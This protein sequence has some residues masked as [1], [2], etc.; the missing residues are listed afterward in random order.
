MTKGLSPQGKWLLVGVSLGGLLMIYV[1]QRA[2]FYSI[3]FKPESHS[4]LAFI[5]NKSVRLIVNDV[6]CLVLIY[7]LFEEKKYV[8]LASW[9][10]LFELF[11]VMP[12]YF[13]IK[14]KMEGDS[15]ISSPLLSQIHR[16]VVNP[17]LMGILIIGLYYQKYWA[18]KSNENE[19]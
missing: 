4:N 9:V 11:I 8:A 18:K 6:L 17:M 16:L 2:D 3:L 13:W 12:F 1:F 14:L 15:E 5:V 10:L 7:A 19:V